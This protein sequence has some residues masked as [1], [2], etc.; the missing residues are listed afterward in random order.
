MAKSVFQTEREC[1]FCGTTVTL[2]CHHMIHGTA[3]RK[4]SEK[5]GLKV[6]LCRYHHSLV[7]TARDVDLELIYAAQRKFE[8]THSREEFRHIFG[9]SY[10]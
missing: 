7:H 6:W 5:Y 9:K 1:Y 8:E 10:L 4:W 2:E 3:N